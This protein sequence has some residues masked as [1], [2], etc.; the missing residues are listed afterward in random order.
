MRENRYDLFL[1]LDPPVCKAL[2]EVLRVL[3]PMLTGL[4]G[5]GAELFELSA[6]ERYVGRTP[7]RR[8]AAASAPRSLALCETNAGAAKAARSRAA[9]A[10]HS[11]LFG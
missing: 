9:S 7:R 8:L 2:G 11:L 3:K 6:F 4:L 10:G 5:A 1:D